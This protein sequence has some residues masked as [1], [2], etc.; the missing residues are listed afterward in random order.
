M[1]YDSWPGGARL[2]GGR[3][4]GHLYRLRDLVECVD[5]AGEC[6]FE[7]WVHIGKNGGK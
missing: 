5:V 3:R 2:L 6:M 1:G 7:D 4:M